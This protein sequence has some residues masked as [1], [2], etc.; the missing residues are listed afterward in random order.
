MTSPSDPTPYAEIV[1]LTRLGVL[2]AELQRANCVTRC[3]ATPPETDR[4]STT[5]EP[6]QPGPQKSDC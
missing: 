3:D 4:V 1:L 2:G 6:H 5:T